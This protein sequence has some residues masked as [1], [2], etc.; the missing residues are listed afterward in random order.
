[1]IAAARGVGLMRALE[2]NVDATPVTE[3]ALANG[4]LVNRTA[5]RVVR[6]LPPLNVT[7]SEIDEAVGVL[8]GVLA[9][10]K[11]EVTP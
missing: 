3:G 6:M 5:E 9:T 7:R 10:L 8:D 11:T 2:L 4:L 1:V